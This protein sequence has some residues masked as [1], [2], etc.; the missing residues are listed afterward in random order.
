MIMLH[1]LLLN[2]WKTKFVHPKCPC[3]VDFSP[4]HAL[5]NCDLWADHDDHV[6]LFQVQNRT[7]YKHIS[8][9]LLEQGQDGYRAI[10]EVVM[11]SDLK[12]WI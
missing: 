3:G 10:I 9:F 11:S 12:N 6:R 1:R 4:T 7:R 8:E 5:L 2:S